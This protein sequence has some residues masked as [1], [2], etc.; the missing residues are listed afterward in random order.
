MFFVFFL[1]DVLCYRFPV[2]LVLSTF[3]TVKIEKPIDGLQYVERLPAKIVIERSNGTVICLQP[4]VEVQPE[5]EIPKKICVQPVVEVQPEK[6]I[7]KKINKK[8][9]TTEK[10]GNK[11]SH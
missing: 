7:P 9:K 1:F 2:E 3:D 10:K 5:K 6:Q 8:Q 4:V 11:E